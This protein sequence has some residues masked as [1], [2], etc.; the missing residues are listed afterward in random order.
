MVNSSWERSLLAGAEAL[1]TEA[2]GRPADALEDLL[3]A[4]E[5]GDRLGI[6]FEATS[7]RVD[8]ARCAVAA[9]RRDVAADLIGAARD[10]ADRMGAQVF[11]DALDLMEGSSRQSDEA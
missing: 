8:A 6:H 5:R 2:A 10:A 4:I 9:N 1:L 3:P 7:L 11:H